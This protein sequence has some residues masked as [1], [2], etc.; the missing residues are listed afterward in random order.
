MKYLLNNKVYD[1]EKSK[2]IIKYSKSVKTPFFNFFV[3]PKYEHTL[4]KTKKGAFFVHIG[5]YLNSSSIIYDDLDCIE[6][7]TEEEVKKILNNL[8]KIEKYEELFGK[9]EEG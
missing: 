5:K 9:L 4:Y 8:N 7:I 6:L 3:Y 2:E 1:T